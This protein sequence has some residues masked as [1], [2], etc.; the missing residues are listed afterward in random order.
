M[1]G[2][3]NPII[4]G[5]S[6]NTRDNSYRNFNLYPSVSIAGWKFKNLCKAI[7]QT[8]ILKRGLTNEEMKNIASLSC[9]DYT[10]LR[11]FIDANMSLQTRSDE[12]R[13][14]PITE[15]GLNDIANATQQAI[16]GG[17][18]RVPDEMF[19]YDE[20]MDIADE[21]VN[22]ETVPITQ[23]LNSLR[24]VS[25]EYNTYIPNDQATMIRLN[26]MTMRRINNNNN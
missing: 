7:Y 5:E 4:F 25:P 19:G 21:I 9:Y 24:D 8:I 6:Q 26:G 20:A 18:N 12:Q 22:S 1:L 10:R 15:I 3:I 16:S 11:T 17:A 13:L 23:M 14:T 2:E